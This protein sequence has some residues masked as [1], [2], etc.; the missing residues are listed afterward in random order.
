MPDSSHDDP[1]LGTP[2]GVSRRR[3]PKRSELIA[4]DL[5]DY[6]VDARLPAGAMLPR[7]RDMIEQLQ[8]G[9]TTLREALRILETRGIITIR[10]GPGGGPVVRHPEPGDLTESLTLILQFQR[11]TL[12]EVHDARIWLE[13]MA[14]RM[15]ASHITSA[16]IRRL[17]ELNEVMQGA[18]DA[19]TEDVLID[20]NTRFHQVIAGATGNVV[21]QVFTETLLTVADTGVQDL[22]LN[23][24]FRRTSIRGHAEIIE[25]LEAAD[26]D[27]A[28]DAMRRHVEEGKRR[29]T[30]ANKELMARALRWVQ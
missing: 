14:A 11:A 1:V 7:E 20:A 30:R 22:K 2:L 8:V 24:E 17:R 23:R 27:R 15:A 21:M 4:R 28:E 19:P 18:V 13:P 3:P 29:R 6:I 16:E 9:R 25:A 26:P 10:S 12:Q 5:V